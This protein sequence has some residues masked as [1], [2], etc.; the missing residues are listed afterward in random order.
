MLTVQQ[1][2]FTVESLISK[3][4]QQKQLIHQL[5]QEK[6]LHQPR[7]VC[8]AHSKNL[9]RAGKLYRRPAQD[10]LFR[11][12]WVQPVHHR[13]VGRGNF[14]LHRHVRMV[15]QPGAECLYQ[16]RLPAVPVCDGRAVS[17][18]HVPAV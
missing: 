5:V 8:T 13:R 12:V 11:R 16:G 3:V 4:Q 17:N 18:G 15:H 1:A 9:C 10:P 7:P 6:G 14:G 2:V